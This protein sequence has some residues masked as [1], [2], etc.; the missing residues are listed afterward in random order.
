VFVGLSEL[1]PDTV[2]VRLLGSGE[3][4]DVPADGLAAWLC[5]RLEGG[6]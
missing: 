6:L 5:E 3:E 2:R 1:P 4:L